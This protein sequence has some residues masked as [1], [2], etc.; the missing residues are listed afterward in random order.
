MR[1]DVAIRLTQ[2]DVL[3]EEYS[4]AEDAGD[5]TICTITQ[6]GELNELLICSG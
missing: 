4:T 3:E 6:R 5:V 2:L 1:K